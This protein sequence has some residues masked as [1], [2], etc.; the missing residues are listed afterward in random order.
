MNELLRT[1]GKA[2]VS[3]LHP[4]MLWLTAVPFL[5]SGLLWG[6]VLWFGWEPVT[7]ALRVWLEQWPLTHW[8]YHFFGYFGIDSLRMTLA[9]FIVVALAVPLIVASALLLIAVL[10]MP[11]VLR[12]LSA[13][14]YVTLEARRGGSALGSLAQS[15]G[16]TLIFLFMVVLTL[17][18]WLVPP[19]FALIPPLLWGWLTYRVM[20]YDALAEHA[21]ADERRSILREHRLPLLVMGVATGLL[22]ALPT[23]LWVSSA[24]M[25]VLFPIVAV[26]VIWLYV[27][28]FVFSALWFAHYCLRALAR[29]R[30]DAPAQRASVAER[31]VPGP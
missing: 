6:V 29:L 8:L 11:A 22:G 5:I 21:T 7:D 2:L 14:H 9:P 26:M 3:L 24:V 15:C 13:R 20:T 16:A 28:I 12:H 17:P 19:F 30:A 1:F 31:A 27:L 25:I 18:F 4:R 23:L 10:S